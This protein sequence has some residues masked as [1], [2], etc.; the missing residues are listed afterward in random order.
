MLSARGHHRDGHCGCGLRGIR[1]VQRTEKSESIYKGNLK[2]FSTREY[3]EKKTG[4]YGVGRLS[5][6]QS[7]V[8]EFQE[9]AESDNETKEQILANLA[10]FAYDPINYEY[11]KKLN[12]TDL[13]L[14]CLDEENDKLVEFAI[15]GIC[16]CC[17]DKEIKD[18]IIGA[19]GIELIIKCLSKPQEN[20]VM[21]AITALMY[22]VTPISKQDI[23][24]L[25]VVECMLR[26]AKCPS[27]Q[28]ANLA[29]V[30]L[31]DYCTPAQIEEAK[32]MQQ[33]LAKPFSADLT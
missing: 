16:N 10:N 14:D 8:T 7:L 5:Y 12:I 11:F 23:T 2:M 27:K 19:S 24:A 6:L 17:L 20:T 1:R 18:H 33:Q 15:G 21:S 31:E 29:Q 4:P 3:L 28:V 25:P 9:S 30:Y 13:F 22:L 26:Y 32:A